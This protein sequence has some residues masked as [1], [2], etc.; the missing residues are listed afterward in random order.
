VLAIKKSIGIG[1]GPP[2]KV[3]ANTA[4]ILFLKSIANTYANTKKVLP[5][6]LVPIPI[7]NINNPGH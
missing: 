2:K 1:I 3:F 4:P 7:A 6:L 5:I